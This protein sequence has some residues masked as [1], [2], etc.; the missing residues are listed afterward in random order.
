MRLLILG[1]TQFLGR[2][3]AT[4]ACAAGHTVTCAARGIAGA[5]PAGARLVKVDRDDADGLA[6]LADETFDAVVDV[7]RH[8]GQ[9]RRAVAALK[10]RATHWTFVS[11]GSVYADSRTPGLRAGT[12]PLKTPVAPEVE[13]ATDANY[14]N[15]KVACEQA[16]GTDAF[17]CRAGLIV[18]PEDPTGRFTYWPARL[19]RGGE[20]L[21]PG[22]PDDLVQFV[23]VRDLAQWIVRCTET[24]RIGCLDGVGTPLPRGEFL[25]QCARGVGA[26]CTFT[27]VDQDFLKSQDVRR[28]AGPRSL[29]LWLPLPELAGFLTRDSTPAREAGLTARSLEDTARDTLAWHSAADVPLTG[30]TADEETA[31]LKAWHARGTN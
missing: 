5:A 28:W 23:D 12:A 19:A 20:V 16:V 22:T 26:G 10:H 30:L 14:G 9:V 29:P 3:I 7:S 2:A 15:A 18:G 11:T 4:H 31:V 25:A 24:R 1:G 13:H 21:A 8:P 27:W 6:P 17:I